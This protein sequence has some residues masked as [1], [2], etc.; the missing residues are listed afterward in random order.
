MP[1]TESNS[2]ESDTAA[3]NPD[4]AAIPVV[5]LNWNGLDDTQDCIDALLET[6]STNF[7]VILVDNGSEGD[8]FD[9][10]KTR[11]GADARMDVRR[12]PENVGFARGMNQVLRELLAGSGQRPEYVALLNNDAVPEAGWLSEMVAS[13]ESTGAGA[14]A[15]KMIRYDDPGKMDNAGHVFLNTG[16]VLPRGAGRPPGDYEEPEPVVGACAGA[17]LFRL[18][19]LEDIGLFDEY[20]ETGYEDAEL[21]LRAMLAGYQQYYVPE[22]VVRHRVSASIDKIRDLRY[23]VRLQVNINY[24]YLKLMPLPVMAWN[25]P[26]ILAKA[27]AML[28][29]PVLVGRFRLFRVQ[30]LALKNS[31]RLMAGAPKSRRQFRKRRISSL[32]VIRRQQFFM[33]Y[34]WTYFKR[35]ILGSEKTAF[36]RWL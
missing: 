13:A 23:A 15:S 30:A 5:V 1:L 25:L 26:W 20:F 4:G 14:I 12:N 18:S 28:T 35:F 17:G 34:Y 22:A 29:V 19:M 31:F 32:D 2:A 8:D 9:H 33:P 16:E 7:R 21:G 3:S 10:L 36:E 27:V 6:T 11:Y 24:T